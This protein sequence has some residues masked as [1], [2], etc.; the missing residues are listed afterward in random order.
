MPLLHKINFKD[1]NEAVSYI[2][3]LVSDQ[4]FHKNY[5]ENVQKAE[6]MGVHLKGDNPESLLK[7][8]RPNEPQEIRDYR[9][10][11]YEPITKSQGKRIVNVLSKIQQSSNYTIEFPEQ[12]NVPEDENLQSY[13]SKNYPF[14]KSLENW[15]FSIALQGGLVDAN[16][17][18]VVMPLTIPDDSVSYLKPYT[19][20]YRSD[21]V[22]DYGLNYYTIL[23]DEKNWVKETPLS[24]WLFVT[25]S[26][27][28]KV[29]QV[30]P[31]KL[32]KVEIEVLYDFSFGEVPAF[33]LK[34]DY[35]EETVPFAY[36]SFVSGIA[37]C[38]N[39]AL[40]MD[41]DLDA[42]YNQH[43]FLE[44]VE[45]ETECNAGCVKDEETGSQVIITH[46]NDVEK[47]TTCSS[48]KGTGWI[49]GRS[50]LG[51][52]VVK[53]EAFDGNDA[54][55]PGVTYIEKPTE[56]IELTEKKV[57]QLV[58]QGFAAVN[59]SIID[60]VGA[61]QSGLA[62][63]IDR[64]E[65]LSFLSKVSD[66]LFDNIIGNSYRFISLWRYSV[67]NDVTIPTINKPTNFNAM[68]ES[69]LVEEIKTISDAGLDT[70]SYEN[71]LIERRYP[72]DLFKQE[73]NK[74]VLSL[75]P[76]VGKTSE[77]KAEIKMNGGV[78][79][80]QFI[81]SSNIRGFILDAIEENE[82]FFEKKR[83]EKQEILNALAR[84]QI[85]KQIPITNP[86]AS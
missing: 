14:H 25:D 40:R 1:Q 78:T 41:S 48:C 74:N 56:I 73:Y 26:Q 13:T 84:K 58:S 53:S 65:L 44:R 36:D 52:T 76:L 75:D 86:D 12:N 15:A 63:T 60:N 24:I 64:S 49:N 79:Q 38:W 69:M 31:K 6:E 27:I 35:R 68:N 62:K 70:T 28:I 39:K 8:Y 67:V 18:V 55:F 32:G 34:G 2:S 11:I 54:R 16:S 5:Y 85:V 37:P 46:V 43:L 80:E 33:F 81:V 59:M 21:Q 50:P 72:N 77:E 19:F 17:L 30:D 66:N 10:N 3:R 20:I 23:L 47:K 9:L 42:Q 29:K 57:E 82:D 4:A 22:I 71:D 83:S 51:V 7:A 45:T 61:N